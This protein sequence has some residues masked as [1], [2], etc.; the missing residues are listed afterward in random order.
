MKKTLLFV[1]SLVIAL[2]TA[3][4]SASASTRIQEKE[5]NNTVSEAQEIQR[6]NK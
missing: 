6:N 5:S 3:S 2:S 1:A 4:I